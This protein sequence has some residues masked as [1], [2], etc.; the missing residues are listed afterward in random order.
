MAR[1]RIRPQQEEEIREPV[2]GGCII[3]PRPVIACPV[4][5]DGLVVSAVHLHSWEEG[6]CVE[7]GGEDDYVC[8][9]EAVGGLQSFGN[10]FEDLCVGQEHLLVVEGVEVVAVEDSALIC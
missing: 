8:F 9:D 10:D 6:V 5:L 2:H 3:R 7:T 4:L 1:D